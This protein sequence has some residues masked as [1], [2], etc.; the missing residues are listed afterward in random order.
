MNIK[1]YQELNAKVDSIWKAYSADI[2]LKRKAFNEE[3]ASLDQLFGEVLNKGIDENVVT[4]EERDILLKPSESYGTKIGIAQGVLAKLGTK[5]GGSVAAASSLANQ[6]HTQGKAA[7]AYVEILKNKEMYGLEGKNEEEILEAAWYSTGTNDNLDPDQIK[8]RV[9]KQKQAERKAYLEGKVKDKKALEMQYQVDATKIASQGPTEKELRD[10]RR[11]ATIEYLEEMQKDQVWAGTTSNSI[12]ELYNAEGLA[13]SIAALGKAGSFTTEARQVVSERLGQIGENVGA[14]NGL[15]KAGKY[16][17]V[18]SNPEGYLS[19]KAGNFVAQRV[20]QAATT[21]ATQA[22]IA[23]GLQSVATAV[24]PIVGNIAAWIVSNVAVKAL[25]G[26]INTIKDGA[27]KAGAAAVGFA[28]IMASA[29]GPGFAIGAG[30]TALIAL[31]VVPLVAL[32]MF[33]INASGYLVPPGTALTTSGT[34]IGQ[35]ANAVVENPYIRV[36]KTANPPG[37][38]GNSDLPLSVQY[39]IVITAKKETLTGVTFK[40]DCQLIRDPSGACPPTDPA[41]PLAPPGGTITTD[42]PFTITYRQNYSVA[43]QNSLVMDNLT[44]SATV[45]SNP[46]RQEASGFA[47]I[48]I[49]NPPT[50][51]FTFKGDWPPRERSVMLAAI[52]QIVRATVYTDKICNGGAINLIYSAFQET[53]QGKAYGGQTAGPNITF[54]PLALGNVPSAFYTLAHESGH[55]LAGRTNLLTLFE[56]RGIPVSP[57]G[58]VCTYPFSQTNSEDFAESI[59]LYF[60]GQSLSSATRD[61]GCMKVLTPTPHFLDLYSKYPKHWCFERKSVFE[62][63]LSWKVDETIC[64]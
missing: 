64:N 5:I 47:S 42:A 6:T 58:T 38:F 44:V 59:A 18:F 56:Q 7:A 15:L 27:K 3:D 2:R 14:V 48:V 37:P 60:V 12:G 41:T 34:I 35:N 20:A 30:A 16:G 26:T 50:R 23:V 57:E 45:A 22:L 46:A 55:V 17:E 24:A 53:Y 63:A 29:I 4:G 10:A 62:N 49:G 43:F 21:K 1:D 52:G 8:A 31:I 61:F 54:Y 36:V 11:L 9:I 40:Y 33:I 51:C 13:I 19:S 39:T 25:R 28:V 32:I